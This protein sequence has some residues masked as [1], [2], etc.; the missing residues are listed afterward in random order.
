M[1]QR[2]RTWLSE[3]RDVVFLENLIRMAHLEPTEENIRRLRAA[4]EGSLWE[5]Q[6]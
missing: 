1:K 5:K 6:K 3:Y 2:I 4:R